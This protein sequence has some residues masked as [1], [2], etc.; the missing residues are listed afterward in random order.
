MRG[1]LQVAL[2][3][4]RLRCDFGHQLACVVLLR[5]LTAHS[6][7]SKYDGKQIVNNEGVRVEDICRV[8]DLAIAKRNL[9][10]MQLRAL[11]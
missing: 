2:I 3:D 4:G 9:E 8:I 1:R 7:T 10:K 6:I 11:K 5:T